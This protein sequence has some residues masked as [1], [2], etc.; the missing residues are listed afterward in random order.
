LARSLLL[1]LALLVLPGCLR[2]RET[3][4]LEADGSG[5]LRWEHE[6][7]PAALRA[8]LA[9][10]RATLGIDVASADLDPGVN[11]VAPEWLRL[12]AKG[13]KDVVLKIETKPLPDGRLRTEAESGF[14]SLEAAAGA[15]AFLGADVALERAPKDGWRLLVRDPWTPLGPGSTTVF[16]GLDAKFVKERFGADLKVLS[17]SL[18]ITFPTPV[19]LT[20]GRV[21][22]DGRTVTWS[23]PAD[24]ET[25]QALIVE[26]VLPTDT[27]WPTFRRRP[28]LAALTRRCLLPPPAP[29]AR[30]AEGAP[31]PATE[32]R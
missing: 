6:F 24:A 19:R 23:A 32:K 30:P 21:A 18:R 25:P 31:A 11:P 8:L 10:V 3:I 1:L 5:T 2:L 26:F 9:R 4:V 27:P 20:N 22:E 13:T 15:G 12:G 17:R 28:D 16:G 7:D 29:P 14:P